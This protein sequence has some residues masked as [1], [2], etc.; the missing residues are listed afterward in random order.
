MVSVIFII[1]QLM[2]FNLLIILIIIALYIDA[3]KYYVVIFIK[4]GEHNKT[5]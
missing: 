2:Q 4:A 1:K 3:Y 5:F